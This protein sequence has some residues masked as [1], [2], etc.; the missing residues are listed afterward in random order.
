MGHLHLRHHLIIDDYIIYTDS[1][2]ESFLLEMSSLLWPVLEIASC[3]RHSE[4]S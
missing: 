1:D 4:E 2:V 3:Q